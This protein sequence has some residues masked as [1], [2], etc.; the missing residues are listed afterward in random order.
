[1]DNVNNYAAFCMDDFPKSTSLHIFLLDQV[2]QLNHLLCMNLDPSDKHGCQGLGI[3]GT[4]L[5][6]SWLPEMLGDVLNT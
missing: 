6:S 5:N 2:L 4:W 3:M 1:M